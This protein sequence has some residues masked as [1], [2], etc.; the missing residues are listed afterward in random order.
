[1]NATI[2]ITAKVSAIS[3]IPPARPK[4]ITAAVHAARAEKP[5]TKNDENEQQRHGAYN[6]YRHGLIEREHMIK[7]KKGEHN[8]GKKGTG[9]PRHCVAKKTSGEL[10]KPG[11][12]GR[13]HRYES[14][15]RDDHKPGS[16]IVWLGTLMM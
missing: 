10:H 11:A 2:A 1:M 16:F 8:D 3:R 12:G 5:A 4:K 7:N 15:P 14:K 13:T 6:P 9:L